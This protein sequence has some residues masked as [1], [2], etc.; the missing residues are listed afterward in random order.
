MCNEMLLLRQLFFSTIT[1][2][3]VRQTSSNAHSCTQLGSFLLAPLPKVPP[4]Q[5]EAGC[6]HSLI[7][8]A[9]ARDMSMARRQTSHRILS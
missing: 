6:A 4:L 1:W 2:L 9:A 5:A 8:S 3:S 7:N